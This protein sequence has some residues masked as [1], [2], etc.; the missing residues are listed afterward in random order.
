MLPGFLSDSC[1]PVPW[2]GPDPT[3]SRHH[4]FSVETAAC[5][6]VKIVKC[7]ERAFFRG[8][9]G[10]NTKKYTEQA[11]RNIAG[12]LATEMLMHPHVP[13]PASSLFRFEP[14][15]RLDASWQIGSGLSADG[16]VPPKA[17]EAQEAMRER[18]RRKK[19]RRIPCHAKAAKN[20]FRVV[21]LRTSWNR[22]GAVFALC[23]G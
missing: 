16:V 12:Y 6:T 19:L 21:A 18:G 13:S 14:L 9:W 2:V 20:G 1:W 17:R 5:K 11:H 8:H 15:L 7:G 10:R 4:W 3:A 22:G 23:Q